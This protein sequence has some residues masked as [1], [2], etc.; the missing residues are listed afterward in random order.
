[1]E[2]ILS[3]SLLALLI[4]AAWTLILVGVIAAL[5]ASL[6]L[7]G[8]RQ[9]NAFAPWGDDVSPFSARLCRAHAN[10]VE[11][12]PLFASVV[13]LAAFSNQTLVTDR[14]ALWAVAARLAQSMVHLMSTSPRAVL[15]RFAFMAAQM[16]ILGWWILLLL[17]K[18]VGVSTL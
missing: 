3:P 2:K 16:L 5:R 17:T 11:N 6:V 7:R 12:L 10:C 9:A 15:I 13:L 4:Y 8:Q 14:Q 18:A 1:M